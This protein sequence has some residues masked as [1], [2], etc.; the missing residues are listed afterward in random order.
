M[1]METSRFRSYHYIRLIAGSVLLLL[2]GVAFGQVPSSEILNPTLKSDEARY[3]PQI[4]LLHQAIAGEKYKYPFHLA[5]YLDAHS[6]QRA[7][8]DSNGIEFVYFQHRVVLKISGIYRAAYNAE[9]LSKNQRAALTFQ[10]VIVPILDRVAQ[11]IPS[12]IDCDGIG[13][14]IL[15]DTRDVNRAYDFEGKEVLTV[16]FSREDAL[17]YRAATDDVKRQQILNRS[18]VFLDG[19]DYGL[20]LGQHDPLNVKA[21]DRQDQFLGEKNAIGATDLAAASIQQKDKERPAINVANIA[22]LQAKYQLQ[23]HT[24]VQQNGVKLH[25]SEKYPPDIEING[26]QA[27]LHLTMDSN[28][29]C[30]QSTSSIYKRAA[31]NFDL[32][33][34]PQLKV[35]LDALPVDEGYS[36]VDFSIISHFEDKNASTEKIEYICP[37][38]ALRSFTANQ[39]ASQD[40][41]NQS[42]VL[43]NGVRITLNLEIV[44]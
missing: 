26:D 37:V 1:R 23:L 20:A 18:E 36:A 13:F 11:N 7:A 40:V 34:A 6:G 31:Q 30:N 38:K 10:D 39:L 22:A 17:T 21:L 14:E 8:L 42:I 24:L 15:Y 27:L 9:Y 3:L 25:L 2:V 16:I 44:E 19:K 12:N 41:I 29:I 35:L 5:R 33:L 43:V 4:R 28:L 32:F